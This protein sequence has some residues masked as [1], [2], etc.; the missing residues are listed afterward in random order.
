M[1]DDRES[2][3]T[4]DPRKGGSTGQ[5]YPEDNPAGDGTGDGPESG[6]G[7]ADERSPDTHAGQDDSPSD[8]TGNPGAAGG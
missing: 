2:D 4:D 6:T 8:A 1:S 5:G 3:Q 7:G